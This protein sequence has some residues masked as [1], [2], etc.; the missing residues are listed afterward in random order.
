MPISGEVF[1]TT[2]SRVIFR[3]EILG[4]LCFWV[5]AARALW[6]MKR[7]LMSFSS[8]HDTF[9]ELI[10]GFGMFLESMLMSKVGY[11]ISDPLF[12]FLPSFDV[13]SPWTPFF[14]F[15]CQGLSFRP[16]SSGSL[17]L[18]FLNLW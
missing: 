9:F 11:C 8:R 18:P 4:E 7:S 2:W 14:M 1:T 5:C 3:P 6:Y 12:A 10:L 17:P 13:F 16:F 15:C